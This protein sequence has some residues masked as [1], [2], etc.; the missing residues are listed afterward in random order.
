[1]YIYTYI[2]RVKTLRNNYKLKKRKEAELIRQATSSTSSASSTTAHGTSKKANKKA[3]K[4]TKTTSAGAD[5]LSAE[6][7]TLPSLASHTED[8]TTIMSTLIQDQGYVRP[9]ILILCPFRSSVRKIVK[10]IIAILGPNTTVSSWEK[11]NEEYGNNY[12]QDDEDG[13]ATG[14]G[15][16]D[17]DNNDNDNKTNNTSIS[18]QKRYSK[19]IDY[20]NIFYDNV[21]DD[22]KLGLQLNPG[23]GKS[24][25]SN[26][27]GERGGEIGSGDDVRG[28]KGG[29]RSGGGSGGVNGADKGSS[30]GSEKGTYLRLYT[31]FYQS[32]IIIASP[33]G[34]KYI[35]EN[36]ETTTLNYDYLSSLEIIY[37]YHCDIMY[38]QNWDHINYILNLCNQLP[39]HV[40]K[41]TDFIRIRPYYLT[42]THALQHRQLIMT[43]V[44]NE[45]CIQATYRQYSNS[46]IGN[47]RIKQIYHTGYITTIKLNIKQIFQKIPCTSYIT[48]SNDKFDYFI[49]NILLQ[50]IR[51]D[52][53]R[54][55]IIAPSYFDYIRIRNELMRREVSRVYKVYMMYMYVM[56]CMMHVYVVIV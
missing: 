44:Y 13:D 26:S 31:D 14:G 23:Q 27:S 11:F 32:D 43:S 22:F 3:A 19:P 6:A 37:L 7:S 29:V 46:I 54:T 39:K 42:H 47:L 5:N 15:S 38:L 49:N 9:R 1:M 4:T 53:K 16:E 2:Y 30:N 36:N 28:E 12:D 52:Q 8:D 45:P 48:Y 24:S 21:D 33:I 10:Q 18:L 56:F 25:N 50:L 34:L 41:D 17:G 20:Q 40:Y 51:Y 35:I 55:L